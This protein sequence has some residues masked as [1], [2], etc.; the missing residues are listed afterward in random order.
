MD[1]E[2]GLGLGKRAGTGVVAVPPRTEPAPVPRKVA[3]EV[4]A[5]RVLARARGDTV[6]VECRDDPEI[7][8]RRRLRRGQSISDADALWL[9]AVNASDDEHLAHLVR[10]ADLEDGN[11][12]M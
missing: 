5:V 7:C 6:G 9:V 12:T 10:V 8:A 2:P 3:I 1:R 11:G 4:N